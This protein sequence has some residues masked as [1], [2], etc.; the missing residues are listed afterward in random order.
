MTEWY[1]LKIFK[2]HYC[3]IVFVI[4]L[5]GAYFLVPKTIFYGL[6]TI[7]GILYMIIF[8]VTLTCIVRNIKE[9]V[10]LVKTYQS[11]IIGIIAAALGLAA[12]Q[13]CGIGAPVCGAAISAGIL[14]VIFPNIFINFLNKYALIIIII[15]IG[16]QAIALYF[17]N[18]FKKCLFC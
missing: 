11:S 4:S 1:L 17:M 10:L 7:L 5:I 16:I 3:K 14:S 13:V 6:Y 15:S 9:K 18:C 8:A 12:L 2:S